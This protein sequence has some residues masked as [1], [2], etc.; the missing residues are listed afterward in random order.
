MLVSMRQVAVRLCH[1]LP[2]FRSQP[3]PAKAFRHWL[4]QL[5][6]G[7]RDVLRVVE[8]PAASAIMGLGAGDAGFG[9]LEAAIDRSAPPSVINVAC[10]VA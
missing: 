6:H 1:V 3:T 2:D 10:A 7:Q 9:Q 8:A 5:P 4:L